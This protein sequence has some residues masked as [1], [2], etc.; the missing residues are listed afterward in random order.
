VL[1]S[2]A[3]ETQLNNSVGAIMFFNRRSATLQL[4]S[5]ANFM[6]TSDNNPLI[7]AAAFANQ[8]Q[9]WKDWVMIFNS[10]K[11]KE[12]RGG[13]KSDIQ[14]A[15]IAAAAKSAKNK[16]LA[17]ISYLLKIGFTPTKIADSFA[18]ASGGATFYRNR[19]NTYKKQ[20]FDQAEAEAKA[21]EDFSNISDETQQSGDP[22]TYLMKHS[23][24]GIQC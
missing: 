14:E 9:Y 21:F 19:V 17:I 8:P 18:I 16:P 10:P 15:E 7:A 5:T 13:L 3:V 4:L 11:L 22:I 1:I 24:P 20:G 12:R 2:L 6:N 23:S